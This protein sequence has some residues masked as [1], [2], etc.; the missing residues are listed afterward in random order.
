MKSA[1]MTVR[2]GL[3]IGSAA[4][5]AGCG[6]AETS[7]ATATSATSAVQQAKDGK[8]MEDQVKQ[9]IEQAQQTGAAQR[10]QAEKDAQ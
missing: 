3:L 8:K 1:A 10:D 6:L 4:L 9:Q 7:V 2:L 5:A